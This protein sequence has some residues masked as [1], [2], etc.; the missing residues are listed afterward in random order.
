[1]KHV[2]RVLVISRHTVTGADVGRKQ[3]GAGASWEGLR[4]GSGGFSAI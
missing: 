4:G 3:C 2:A 1:M